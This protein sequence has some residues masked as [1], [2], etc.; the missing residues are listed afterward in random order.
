MVPGTLPDT[1]LD[2]MTGL[3]FLFF[4]ARS[5]ISRHAGLFLLDTRGA[6][7]YILDD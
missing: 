5:S 4:G 7:D 6:P 2:V 3:L 1:F